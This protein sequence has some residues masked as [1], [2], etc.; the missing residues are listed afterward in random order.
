MKGQS[1]KQYRFPAYLTQGHEKHLLQIVANQLRSARGARTRESI[2]KAAKISVK[3]VI[4]LE[5]GE[6]RLNL[7]HLRDI[8]RQGYR[9]NFEELLHTCYKENRERFDPQERRP[10]ER[11]Q[12]YSLCLR[13]GEGKSATPLLIGGESEKYLWAVPMR[14]L[15]NQPLVTEFLELAPMRKRKP[16]GSTPDNA[17]E[18]VEVI[19]VMHGTVQANIFHKG[20]SP[21]SRKLKAG[22]CFHFHARNAH[23]IENVEKSTS[24]LL[25]IVRLPKV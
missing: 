3:T 15:K 22:E 5:K 17:H 6:F 13:P 20:D 12:H 9:T 14:K 11:D 19:F 21:N 16:S 7:G 25:L 4:A 2:A 10:F 18:G 23:T 24:A 8:V 1:R